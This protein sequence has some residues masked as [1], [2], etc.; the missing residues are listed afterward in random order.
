ME[1]EQ[2]SR[3]EVYDNEGRRLQYYDAYGNNKITIDM[4]PYVTGVYFVRVHM[5]ES[6]VI[7]KIIKER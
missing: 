4:T 1:A 7:Q 3:V 2:I 5:P 6:V